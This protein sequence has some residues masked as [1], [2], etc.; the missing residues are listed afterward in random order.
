MASLEVEGFEQAKAFFGSLEKEVKKAEIN[1]LNTM[2]SL[3]RKDTVN[4]ISQETG[5]K[6]SLVSKATQTS[7]AGL[8]RP[9]AKV[10]A[11]ALGTPAHRFTH[12]AELTGNNKT[13]GRIVIRWIGGTERVVSGFINPLGKRQYTLRSRNKKGRLKT[14]KTAYGP[15]I[16][17][18]MKQVLNAQ[19]LGSYQNKIVETFEQKLAD[20]I[21]KRES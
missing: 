7:R 2:A 17:S 3:I 6:Q 19:R 20:Q 9:E 16:S 11:S 4:T 21:N 1:T 15:S 10:L 18:A 8:N 14:L 5:I 13:R 12:R